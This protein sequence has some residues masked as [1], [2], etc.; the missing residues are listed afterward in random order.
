MDKLLT[1]A[2][3]LCMVLLSLVYNV[4]L[5]LQASQDKY[6]SLVNFYF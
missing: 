1:H 5:E 2:V 6:F 3:V 4:M